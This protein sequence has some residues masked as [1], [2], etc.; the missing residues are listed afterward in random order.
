MPQL[1]LDLLD[2]HPENANAMSPELLEKLIAHIRETGHCP[3]LIVRPHPEHQGRYQLLDGHHRAIA[4]RK[5]NH[6]HAACEVWDVDDDQAT[7]L[8]LTLN[9]LHGEDDPQQ[10]GMLLKRLSQHMEIE[11]LASKLPED[12]DR[13][14][15]L[16]ALTSPPPLPAPPQ[17]L[18]DLPHAV[19]F[20]LTSAQRRSLFAKLRDIQP[21]R[22]AALVALLEL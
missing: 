5:L 3:P 19:T 6:T 13:I 20:F 8:L 12:V 15:R 22:S 2:A 10:R 1:A 16:I 14:N 17:A 7:M 11:T 18:D 4:L 21:D 9:R